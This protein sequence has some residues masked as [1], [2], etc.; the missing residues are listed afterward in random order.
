[1]SLALEAFIVAM[2]DDNMYKKDNKANADAQ[3]P[4]NAC[5]NAK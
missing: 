3:N 2:N 1:M 5:Q 4:P